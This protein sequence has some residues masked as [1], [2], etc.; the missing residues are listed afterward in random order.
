MRSL[1]IACDDIWP[2]RNLGEGK[3]NHVILNEAK[4]QPAKVWQSE[5][6]L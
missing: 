6:S 1:A 4:Q 5:G 3:R 2:V